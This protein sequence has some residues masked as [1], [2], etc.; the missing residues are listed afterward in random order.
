[1]SQTKTFPG[2]L[3]TCRKLWKPAQGL[4]SSPIQ[5]Q[6]VNSSL[7]RSHGHYWLGLFKGDVWSP[8]TAG[9]RKVKELTLNSCSEASPLVW[10]HMFGL[11]LVE[12]VCSRLVLVSW[13]RVSLWT[14]LG[15]CHITQGSL[16]CPSYCPASASQVLG[17]DMHHHAC[18]GVSKF[19]SIQDYLFSDNI[20]YCF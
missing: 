15:T 3:G 1:M 8:L 11:L 18:F 17:F 13:S 9:N 12:R 10:I 16:E 2:C 5:L 4:I 20:M 14:G 7:V 6:L 19:V